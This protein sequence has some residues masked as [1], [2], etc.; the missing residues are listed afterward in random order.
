MRAST[1]LRRAC[2]P[3][4]TPGDAA[5]QGQARLGAQGGSPA[6]HIVH[7]VPL[8][9]RPPAATDRATFG[10]WVMHFGNHGV[11]SWP[12]V[13]D[14]PAWCSSP[15]SPASMP[16]S[17]P[18]PSPAC[19]PPSPR[20]GAR[21]SPSTTAPSSPATTGE[22]HPD[23]LLRY[24]IPLAEGRCG[25]RHRPPTALDGWRSEAAFTQAIQLY[26][27]TPRKCLGYRTPA[28]TFDVEVLHLECELTFPLSRE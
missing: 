3:R 26:N 10:H 4:T 22:E 25:E 11:R 13:S 20:S 23:L 12:S 14:T 2:A 19:W 15:A 27:N 16:T 9:Q 5:G 1:G 6:T 24:P 21:P 8:S 17:P 28:E 7:R 18:T